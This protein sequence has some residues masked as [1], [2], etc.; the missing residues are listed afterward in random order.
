VRFLGLL[1]LLFLLG[2]LGLFSA[3]VGAETIEGVVVRVI[4]DGD[5]LVLLASGNV[6]ERVRLSGIDCPERGQ[7]F[8]KRAKEAL[9]ERVAGETVTV[10]WDKRD[11]WKRIIG[12]IV[13]DA[14]DVNLALVRDWMC[15]WYRTRASR[16]PWIGCS[17]KRPRMPRGGEGS[18]FGEIRI[19]FR[20]RSGGGG[21]VRQD[22]EG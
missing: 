7:A 20:R 22:E 6:E 11:R 14:G 10:E 4:D 12:K 19:R 17:M 8:G 1:R 3:V 13:D 5:T 16:R 21:D 2:F 18:G 9:G 15:W